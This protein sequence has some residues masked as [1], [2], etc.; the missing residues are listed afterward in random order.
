MLIKAIA[1]RG[2]PIIGYCSA[3][4]E[5]VRT[6]RHCNGRKYHEDC[7][8]IRELGLFRLGQDLTKSRKPKVSR[9]RRSN[10]TTTGV[11]YRQKKTPPTV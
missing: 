5:Y 2:K 8:R 1:Q 7:E 11:T 6:R 4:E 9:L 10:G 3:R